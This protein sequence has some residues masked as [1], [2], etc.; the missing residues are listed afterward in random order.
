M[1]DTYQRLRRSRA[2]AIGAE[3]ATADTPPPPRM[4]PPEVVATLDAARLEEDRRREAVAAAKAREAID[5]VPP[6]I[7][8]AS[9]L[10]GMKPSEIH[11]VTEESEGVVIV[12]RVAGPRMVVVSAAKP[13]ALGRSGLMLLDPAPHAA[14]PIYAR[15][16]PPDAPEPVEAPPEETD[17]P[18]EEFATSDARLQALLATLADASARHGVEHESQRAS[19]EL[20]TRGLERAIARRRAVLRDEWLSKNP[21]APNP[22][23]VA[24]YTDVYRW[25]VEVLST[26]SDRDLDRVQAEW[27][28]RRPKLVAVL[29]PTWAEHE[30]GAVTQWFEGHGLPLPTIDDARPAT[31]AIQ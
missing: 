5:G 29:S 27:A 31:G 30:L 22:A 21:A 8:A 26:T 18:F 11:S 16:A 10:T 1:E 4:D 6:A 28:Q 14:W 23:D 15:E 3:I 7:L 20:E 9:K 24:W 2:A 17:D 12:T 13:D 25:A 19:I